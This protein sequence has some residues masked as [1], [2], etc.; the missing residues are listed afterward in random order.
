MRFT[1][2]SN[3]RAAEQGRRIA[4]LMGIGCT[5]Y[6]DSRGSVASLLW[7]Q[8]NALLAQRLSLALLY[9]LEAAQLL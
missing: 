7:L 1:V 9:W 3:T 2:I 8:N 6:R 5:V 4:E